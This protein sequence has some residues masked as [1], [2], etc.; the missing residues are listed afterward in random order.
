MNTSADTTKPETK[1][2]V[3]LS[4]PFVHARPVAATEDAGGPRGRGSGK[5][6]AGND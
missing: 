5:E 2:T 6:G 3:S 4:G 1:R